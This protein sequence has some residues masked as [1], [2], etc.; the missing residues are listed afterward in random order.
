MLASIGP[1]FDSD[2]HLF[3]V[4]WDGIRS[5][6]FC[7]GGDYRLR[8]RTRNDQRARYPELALFADLP[9][10]TLLDGELVVLVD[11]IPSFR[12][13]MSRERKSAGPALAALAAE[14]PVSYVAFDVLYHAGASVMARPLAARREL[15]ADLVARAAEPRLVLSDGVVGAGLAFF[16]GIR[17]RAVEGMV[18][19]RLD[20]AY[21]PGKRTDAWI[22]VKQRKT[23]LALILGYL[24]PSV[25]SLVIATDFGEGA[26]LEPVG[27]VGSGLTA[28]DCARIAELGAGLR[29]AEPL[30]PSA[31]PAV[32]L[33]PRL[34]CRISYLERTEHGLRA[35]VFHELVVDEGG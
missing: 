14:E 7:E 32:W 21:L 9:A 13:V 4:K 17:A 22:K 28:R 15:L 5:L 2:E 19:K 11:G 29:R 16:A 24:G 6:A 31:E 20:S 30:L 10:G 8:S 12:A 34:F 33:E 23:A 26:G 1:A 27:R 35:P 3:E 25:Q 18:A